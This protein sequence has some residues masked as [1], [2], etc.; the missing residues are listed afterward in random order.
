MS[1]LKLDVRLDGFAKPVGYL[2]KASEGVARF[3]Y[4]ASY[5]A[6]PSAVPLSLSLPLIETPFTETQARP[7]F[8]NLLQER[9]QPIRRVVERFN[10]DANDIVGLLFHLGTECAGAVSVLPEGA[11]PIKVPGNPNTDYVVLSQ[12]QIES[13][14]LALHRREPLPLDRFDNSPL[15]GYQSKIS[16]C[17]LADGTYALAKGR[18]GAPTTHVLKVPDRNHLPDA[19]RE[20]LALRLSSMCGQ[21]SI[22]SECRSI[23]GIDCLITTRFDRTVDERGFV[24]RIHQEDFAQALALPPS[25]KYQRYGTGDRIFNAEAIASVLAQTVSPPT[26]TLG[27]IR[28]TIFDL[29]IG[30]A[31]AHA[32]NHALVY[33]D[34]KRPRPSLRYDI[35]PT[36]LDDTISA[37]LPFQIG[38]ASQIEDVDQQALSIFLNVLGIKST[39]G[40]LRVIA[41]SLDAILPPLVDN[42]DILQS[43][44]QKSFADLIAANMH[45]LLPKLGYPVPKQA[46]HRDAHVVRGGGWLTS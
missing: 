12:A 5:L 42:L 28:D 17:C 30:N 21:G 20:H 19:K 35:L 29:L 16:L 39:R 13:V 38:T 37:E 14:V 34:N 18:T 8:A 46:E 40:Q 36:R 11:P 27:F 4:D 23:A 24:H 26:A 2:T 45:E 43:I 9:D 44:N 3:V 32:K 33:M 10:V 6:Q 15:S 41:E 25:L 1:E 22:L 7:F 31:D